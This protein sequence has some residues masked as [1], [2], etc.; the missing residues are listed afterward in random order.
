MI[1]LLTEEEIKQNHKVL[2]KWVKENLEN[3]EWG[4]KLENVIYM[5][6]DLVD[7]L[8]DDAKKD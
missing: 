3:K 6:K 7:K 1:T 5:L 4:Y 8:N 2:V